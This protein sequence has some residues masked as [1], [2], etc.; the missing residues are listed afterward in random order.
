MRASIAWPRG[1]MSA[2]GSRVSGSPCAMRSCHSHEID[3]GD[4]LRDRVFHLQPRVH[5]EEVELA[6]GVE[7][8]LDRPCVRVPD[9]ARH[10]RSRVRRARAA[11][12]AS[13]RPTDSPRPPS[14]AAA[15]WSTRAPRMAGRCRA[16]RQAAAPRCG[17][18][19]R[20]AAPDTRRHRQT[21]TAPRCGPP[22]SAS[23]SSLSSM[24]RRMPLPP[25]PATAFSMSG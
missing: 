1:V 25:P 13:P 16:H 14:G 18:G 24:T 8:E 15:G 19:V 3:A 7:Q 11:D 10:A 21:T 20:A 12:P 5:L 6:V 2:S 22:R 23:G 17:A 4:H 9:A